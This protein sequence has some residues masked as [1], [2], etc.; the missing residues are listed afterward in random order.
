MVLP[1]VVL[2][3]KIVTP[4]RDVQ[5]SLP[6]GDDEALDA[7]ADVGVL[8]DILLTAHALEGGAV[9]RSMPAPI[10]LW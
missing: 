7:V 6:V 1:Q 2:P 4:G 8:A 9:V 3:G 10:P 5:E